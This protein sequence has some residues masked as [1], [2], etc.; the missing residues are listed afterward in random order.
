MG[1][2]KS[3]EMIPE[4]SERG[5]IEQ[6]DRGQVNVSFLEG[7][8]MELHF[9]LLKKNVQMIF[10][11]L[12]YY[13]YLNFLVKSHGMWALSSPTR[14]QTCAPLQWKCQVLTTGPPDMSPNGAEF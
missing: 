7:I 9:I 10:I 5:G 12:N 4:T 11:Y 1:M 8:S 3:A 14:D 2:D 13:Y 6:D